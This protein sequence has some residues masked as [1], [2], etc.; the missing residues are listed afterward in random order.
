LQHSK[1]RIVEF[2]SASHHLSKEPVY[3]VPS[4]G[5]NNNPLDVNF[6]HRKDLLNAPTSFK[7]AYGS[8]KGKKE[9]LRS[10]LAR[11]FTLVALNKWIS[12]LTDRNFD[13]VSKGEF[14]ED[15]ATIKGFSKILQNWII[16]KSND[17]INQVALLDLKMK[18]QAL[19]DEQVAQVQNHPGN[20]SSNLGD[21]LPWKEKLERIV[22]VSASIHG[23]FDVALNGV[24]NVIKKI[25]TYITSM[26]SIKLD[27]R[28]I[29]GPHA[30]TQYY[31]DSHGIHVN[32]VVTNPQVQGVGNVMENAVKGAKFAPHKASP[33]KRKIVQKRKPVKKQIKNKHHSRDEDDEDDE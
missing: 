1:I 17:V 3:E 31:P 12:H 6:N 22:D 5:K 7:R 28:R 21:N 18:E 19:I 30:E 13:L 23:E 32:E 27:S 26:K 25:D 11:G 2:A 24:C 29:K 8:W 15:V 10:E 4:I 16:A 14:V 9:D 33:I 20:I